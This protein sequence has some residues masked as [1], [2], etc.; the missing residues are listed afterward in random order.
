M[1]GGWDRVCVCRESGAR[2]WFR[3]RLGFR[4]RHTQYVLD[5]Q[6]HRTQVDAVKVKQVKQVKEAGQGM[7]PSYAVLDSCLHSSRCPVAAQLDCTQ[8]YDGSK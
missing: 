3:S 8:V 2:V 1:C 6:L 4:S 7:L 5:A